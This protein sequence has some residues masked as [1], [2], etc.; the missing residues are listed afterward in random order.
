MTSLLDSFNNVPLYRYNDDGVTKYQF[1]S[2]SDDK[3]QDGELIKPDSSGFESGEVD[4]SLFHISVMNA[5]VQSWNIESFPVDDFTS[6]FSGTG[7]YEDKAGTYSAA[8]LDNKDFIWIID[9][10]DTITT[11]YTEAES[12]NYTQINA[13]FG[14]WLINS[15]WAN[16][17]GDSVISELENDQ[18]LRNALKDYLYGLADNPLFTSYFGFLPD[19]KR[20]NI[21]KNLVLVEGTY[22]DPS[23]ITGAE[24]FSLANFQRTVSI[25]LSS[26]INTE[27]ILVGDGTGEGFESFLP[28]GGYFLGDV[29]EFTEITDD[30]KVLLLDPQ[31]E[32]VPTIPIPE[33]L[34][35]QV[36][37][38]STAGK[39][40]IEAPKNN[41]YGEVDVASLTPF[42]IAF[43]VV[44][45]LFNS[46]ANIGGSLGSAE[47][48][49][50]APNYWVSKTE[51][52]NV[53]TIVIEPIT[54]QQN[55]LV[56]KMVTPAQDGEYVTYEV[57][58]E[59]VPANGLVNLTNLDIY[60]DPPNSDLPPTKMNMQEFFIENYLDAV[61]EQAYTDYI[62]SQDGTTYGVF[63]NNYAYNT[64]YYL[65]RIIAAHEANKYRA[66]LWE[67][68][69]KSTDDQLDPSSDLLE[70]AK[71]AQKEKAKASQPPPLEEEETDELADIRKNAAAQCALLANIDKLT[72]KYIDLKELLSQQVDHP[73]HGGANFYKSR[74]YSIS[75]SEP[76][77]TLTK[78]QAG[79]YN[80]NIGAFLGATPLMQAYLVPK[81][82][83]QKVFINRQ[84][85]VES[86]DIPFD[87]YTKEPMTGNTPIDYKT[88][89]QTPGNVF[90]GGGSGI[91]SMSFEFDG[92]TPATADKYVKADLKLF[93]Q[94]FNSLFE[95]KL[96]VSH[97]SGGSTGT[98]FKYIDLLVNPLGGANSS[99]KPET[100]A[101]DKMDFYDPSFY[102]IKVEIGWD[103][104]DNVPGQQQLKNSLDQVN[105][106]FMLCALDHEINV[107][108]DGT[109]EL[110]I[111]YRGYGDTLLKTNR[112]NALIPYREQ[113]E[114]S[115]LIANYNS[116]LASGSCTKNQRAEFQATIA[117]LQKRVANQ[118]A[119]RVIKKMT[120]NGLIHR[121][122]IPA[123]ANKEFQENGVFTAI[124]ELSTS[125]DGTLSQNSSDP[126][127]E[128]QFFFLGDLLFTILDCQYFDNTGVPVVGAE[129]LK[130]ILTDMNIR[131]FLPS[132]DG[133]NRSDTMLVPIS[134]IPIAIQQYKNWFTNEILGTDRYNMPVMEFIQRFTN[135]VCGCFLS[136]I[137]FTKE[138]DKSI[139]FRQGSIIADKSIN[140]SS[141]ARS[142]KGGEINI[143][144]TVNSRSFEYLEQS[145]EDE[146][147]NIT[148]VT[149]GDPLLVDSG[150]A[151]NIEPIKPFT[152]S[153]GLHGHEVM[154][155]AVIYVDTP[156]KHIATGTGIS[157]DNLSNGI[158]HLNIGADRGI[159]KTASWSKQNVQY[160]REARMFRSQGIGNYAQLATYYN[161]SLNMF[162]NFLLTPGMIFYLDPFGIGGSKFGRPN[163]PGKESGGSGEVNFSRLMGIGGYHLVTGVN[164]SFT[165]QKFETT[166]E[167][168]FLFSGDSEE[169]GAVSLS[170]NIIDQKNL[171][172]DDR[173]A[174]EAVADAESCRAAISVA[175]ATTLGG[176]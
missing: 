129:N 30:N 94:D 20:N 156:P 141:I 51:A 70:A 44:A 98:T 6:K 123:D 9:N 112:F 64:A 93:F 77:K 139:F 121:A 21:I 161:V 58:R 48:N 173:T 102:R 145:F 67:T 85:V 16:E 148:T 2:D 159:L 151:L 125:I 118:A 120:S 144:E 135:D 171:N 133:S 122:S 154:E 117:S 62:L 167:G 19:D 43:S 41:L 175:Q 87:T 45:G 31:A 7:Q 38:N 96:T 110:S 105:K 5:F 162:G 39:I 134:S 136:E 149:D 55:D 76:T 81:I 13:A 11:G 107:N 22:A 170:R 97:S 80:S 169:A 90:K 143:D 47:T 78:L 88:Q 83:L 24:I 34:T 59:I 106:T 61:N 42:G 46:D 132:E 68:L 111:S 25:Y 119:S 101:T 137:C 65:L 53:E 153:A 109:V 71:N 72:Q 155:Y 17:V 168:R 163:E 56:T 18:N 157:S 92:E 50:L 10:F 66:T 73:V 79:D 127:K 165:P 89:F 104:A 131:Q 95:D 140:V 27:N 33:E 160:L 128:F 74:F 147:G 35:W 15:S 1:V 176:S 75:S 146:F 108:N 138:E 57:L 28:E 91:K 12:A 3:P 40:D 26:M 158:L 82:K 37:D 172:I 100:E 29:G 36:I 8:F 69:W 84:G 115:A 142:Y 14:V 99:K 86:I 4:S 103:M 52:V 116:E 166:V 113:A 174:A 49:V 164:V 124:P 114:I 60:L 152:L 54:D 32:I 130:I 23:K 150:N 63:F 126:V